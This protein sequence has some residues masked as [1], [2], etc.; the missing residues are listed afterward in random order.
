MK[1]KEE[2]KALKEEI[3]TLKE[4]LTE[5][6]EEELAQVAGGFISPRLPDPSEGT[7]GKVT[8]HNMPKKPDDENS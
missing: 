8:L 6:N 4:K 7:A 3:D 2:L 1:T 5:L